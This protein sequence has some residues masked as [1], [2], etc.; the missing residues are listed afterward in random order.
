MTGAT[1]ERKVRQVEPNIGCTAAGFF[2]HPNDCTRF[3]RCVD[4]FGTGERFSIFFFDCPAGTI[5]DE[6]L[7]VCNHPEW[8]MGPLSCMGGG[9]P[10]TTSGMNRNS[11]I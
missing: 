4:F 9:N 1:V 3:Y 8:V 10:S 6:T 7:S 2:V 11:M 5:F